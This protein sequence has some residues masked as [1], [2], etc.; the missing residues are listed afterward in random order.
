[1]NGEV[2]GAYGYVGFFFE[3]FNDICVAANR[4]ESLA[5]SDP[6]LLFVLGWLKAERQRMPVLCGKSV[7]KLIQ[8]E[9]SWR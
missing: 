5:Q 3:L 9:A 6:N 1:M 4:I 8:E 2:Q 7:K